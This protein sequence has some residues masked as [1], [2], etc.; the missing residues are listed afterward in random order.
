V[1]AFHAGLLFAATVLTVYAV[2][3]RWPLP[4]PAWTPYLAPYAI[5]AVAM[6]WVIDRI[7]AF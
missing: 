5:G 1:R 7:G 6:F 4:R 3:S 2:V